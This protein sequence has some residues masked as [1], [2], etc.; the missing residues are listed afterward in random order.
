MICSKIMWLGDL[1]YRLTTSCSETHQLLQRNDW[2]ALLEKD[3]VRDAIKFVY[4]YT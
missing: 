2:E 3:Q 4:V 1:N